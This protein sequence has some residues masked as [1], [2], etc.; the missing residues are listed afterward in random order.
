M[1]LF[2]P[3]NDNMV[4]SGHQV[5]QDSLLPLQDGTEL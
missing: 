4:A 1:T 3:N 5:V 2:R